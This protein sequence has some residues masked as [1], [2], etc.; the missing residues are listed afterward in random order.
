MKHFSRAFKESVQ[1]DLK[2][3]I[4][5]FIE[6]IIIFYKNSEKFIPGPPFHEDTENWNE[7]RIILQEINAV[8][9]QIL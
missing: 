7:I 2:D 4:L 1:Q 5:Q 6:T 8:I 9:I 3:H